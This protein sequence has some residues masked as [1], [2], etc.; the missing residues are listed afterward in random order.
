MAQY[1]KTWW[2]QKWLEAF[3]G[4]DEDNRLPRG[5]TYANKGAVHAVN[6][7]GSSVTAKV[8][9]SGSSPYKISIKQNSFSKE[10][11]AQILDLVHSS[12]A[13]LSRLINRELPESLL[14]KIDALG[15]QTF[16]R[17]WNNFEAMCSCPDWALP[18]KHLAAVIYL[19]AN[20]IDRNPFLVF[21]LHD[22]D[23]QRQLKQSGMGEQQFRIL[24]WLK[25]NSINRPRFKKSM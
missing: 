25:I 5:R 24:R 3:N 12:P 20:K 19:I 1:G 13:I 18:C 8:Q 2:G 6:M 11:Q 7:R 16:P 9:G 15:I 22:F 23:L 17:S 14:K 21:E 10:E 4:I